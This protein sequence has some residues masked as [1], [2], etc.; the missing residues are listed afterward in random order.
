MNCFRATCDP[1]VFDSV[2]KLAPG[3]I[4]CASDWKV[5]EAKEVEEVRDEQGEGPSMGCAGTN[6][7]LARDK[8]NIDE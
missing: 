7:V 5:E 2:E 1:E 4:Q 3:E 6:V 8:S